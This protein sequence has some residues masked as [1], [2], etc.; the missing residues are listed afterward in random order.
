MS[1][2]PLFPQLGGDVRPGRS[3]T[4]LAPST[5]S[6][7]PDSG[8]RV[9]F[10]AVAEHRSSGPFYAGGVDLAVRPH[11]DGILVDVWVVPGAKTTQIAGIHERA[12]RIRVAAPPEHGRANAAAAALVARLVGAR[13][14]RVVAGERSRR[15]Q[16]LVEGATVETARDRLMA[17]VAGP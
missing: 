14:G 13:R 17:R 9:P 12:L 3:C 8:R 7:C 10:I 5:G 16:V 6:L 11:P 15:K 2:F 1:A 4:G